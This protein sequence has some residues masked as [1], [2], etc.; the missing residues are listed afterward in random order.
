M[1]R[2]PNAALGSIL[3]FIVPLIFLLMFS[4]YSYVF[5]LVNGMTEI[6][7]AL[8]KITKDNIGSIDP[9]SVK[10]QDEIA[11]A[12]QNYNG[13]VTIMKNLEETSRILRE[14]GS[15]AVAS[16]ETK[17]ADSLKTQQSHLATVNSVLE[18]AADHDKEAL[19][20]DLANLAKE[21]RAA[22]LEEQNILEAM[23]D[24]MAIVRS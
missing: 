4:M 5:R 9:L 12:K 13:F 15:A 10:G 1:I 23:K 6:S 17:I 21:I 7:R 8:Q 16:V 20:K 3:Q 24:V 11:Q 14:R 18:D 2:W 19:L 22:S